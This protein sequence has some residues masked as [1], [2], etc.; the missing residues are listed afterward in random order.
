MRTDSK[1]DHTAE[2]TLWRFIACMM[3]AGG[4]FRM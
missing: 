1:E 2:F 4:N 3:G